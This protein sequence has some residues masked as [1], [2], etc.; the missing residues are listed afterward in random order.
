MRSMIGSI[1]EILKFEKENPDKL[2][3]IPKKE[4]CGKGRRVRKEG[5]FKKGAFFN[6][7][8]FLIG[9][10]VIGKG[11]IFQGKVGKKV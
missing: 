3:Q 2:L 4:G 6:I 11:I 1:D 7:L 10:E 5:S 9:W 8:R